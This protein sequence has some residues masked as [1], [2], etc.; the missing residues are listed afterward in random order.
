MSNCE[1]IINISTL[2]LT[3]LIYGAIV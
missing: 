3:V 1:L 2:D